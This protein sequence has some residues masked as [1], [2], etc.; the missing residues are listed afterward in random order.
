MKLII[1]IPAYN[2]EKTL[3]RTITNIRRVMDNTK[4]R[5]KILVYNDGSRDNTVKV[6]RKCGAIVYSNK[7]N[8]GLAETFKN[9]MKACIKEGADIIVHI[10]ADSQYEEHAIPRLINKIEQGYDL[11]IGSRFRGRIQGMPLSKRI[12]NILFSKTISWL[13]GTKIT[14]STTGF[15]AFTKEVAREINI[16]NT[17]TYTQEQLIKAAQQKFKIAEIPVNTRKT[18]KSKL[19][20][21]T[22][23]YAVKAWI[24]I[25]RI[26][27]DYAPL[28]FFGLFG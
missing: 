12:G 21:S 25:F 20:K 4:Y 10:D 19:F 2:E 28:K 26:Y 9:E 17:F 8:L 5:Y 22:I 7:R 11:V 13:I 3:G 14:D 24:N 27:R 6:A 15:R 16:I 1:T 18:R 23:E